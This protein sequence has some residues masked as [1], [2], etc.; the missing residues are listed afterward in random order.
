MKRETAVRGVM[1]YEPFDEELC[2]CGHIGGKHS[3]ESPHPC[4]VK[5][6]KCEQFVP[7]FEKEFMA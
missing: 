4:L 5:D 7:D 3:A 1:S 6:C 2:D